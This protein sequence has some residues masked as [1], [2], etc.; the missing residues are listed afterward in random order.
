MML[1]ETLGKAG[2]VEAYRA[3]DGRLVGLYIAGDFTD[4][5]SFPP[6]INTPEEQAHLAQAYKVISPQRERETKAHVTDDEL[7]LQIVL[8]NRDSG[9]YVRPH[10]HL[11]DTPTASA[12]RHQVLICQRGRLRV[13]LYTKEGERLGHA[14]LRPGDLVLSCE[15]HSL[16]FQEPDTKAIEIKM[17]PFPGSD[18]ADKVD[19]GVDHEPTASSP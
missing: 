14:V 3:A 2:Q 18:A 15:G 8:L 12:T 7:P 1:R 6:F 9:A 4:Y 5:T 11:N 17:G 19:L 16:E 13:G 10:Y